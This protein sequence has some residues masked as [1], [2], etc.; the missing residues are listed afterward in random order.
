MFNVPD[1]LVV[2]VLLLTHEHIYIYKLYTVQCYFPPHFL[3]PQW[4]AILTK[5]ALVSHSPYILPKYMFLNLPRDVL[6]STARFR[7]RI[8]TLRFETATWNQNYSPT[9]DLCDADDIQ[10]S[11]MSLSTAPIPTWFLSAGICTFVSPNRSSRCIYFLE[12]EQWQALS[13]FSMNY[14]RNFLARLKCGWNTAKI[15]STAFQPHTAEINHV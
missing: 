2:H 5:R 13:F 4:D 1:P 11:S 15:T 3:Y 8:H 6:R 7:I 9:C 12:P 10:M 14:V